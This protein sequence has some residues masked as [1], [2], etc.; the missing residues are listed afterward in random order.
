MGT[1]PEG[2]PRA[3]LRLNSRTGV[4]VS[5]RARS[6]RATEDALSYKQCN[7][8]PREPI[9]GPHQSPPADGVRGSQPPRDGLLQRGD[10]ALPEWR[11]ASNLS[12][13]WDAVRL[14]P[15]CSLLSAASHPAWDC[16][17]ETG[18]SPRKPMA[19]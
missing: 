11:L 6:E 3:S 18:T 19:S 12:P 2:K 5:Q 17:Q 7:L 13:G 10:G 15:C 1:G 8:R 14:S 16:P 9:V 4:L